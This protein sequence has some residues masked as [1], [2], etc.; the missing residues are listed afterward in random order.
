MHID[1]L[2]KLV[3]AIIPQVQSRFILDIVV[4]KSP[5]IL[6]LLVIEKQ[7]PLIKRD[8]FLLLGLSLDVGEGVRAPHLKRDDIAHPSFNEDLNNENA[9]KK[10]NFKPIC[11]TKQ[12]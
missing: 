5:P 9:S 6:Q 7:P 3:L 8:A 12:T 2:E 10:K 1:N 11:A 4:Q